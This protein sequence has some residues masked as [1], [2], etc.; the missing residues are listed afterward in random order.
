MNEVLRL[1]FERNTLA[2][3]FRWS[4]RPMNRNIQG[5]PTTTTTSD[6]KGLWRSWAEAETEKRVLYSVWS[7]CCHHLGFPM[8]T[9][10]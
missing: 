6:I 2:T 10:F 4:R 8:Y 1:Q 9:D 5:N 7:E 3:L